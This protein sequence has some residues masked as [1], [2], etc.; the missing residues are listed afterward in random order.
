[1]TRLNQ[2]LAVEK[3]LKATANRAVTDLY[4]SFQK[5]AL[6]TGISR[7]YR[8]AD[9]DSKELL[10]AENQPV[11][12]NAFRALQDATRALT[13]LIDVTAV[14]DYANTEA[15]ADVKI[16]GRV[17]LEAVP[18]SHLLFLEKQLID[19]QTM[20]NKL[21]VL[22]PSVEWTYDDNAESYRSKAVET[23]RSKK[24]PRNHVLAAATDKHPAQVQ[25][26]QEDVL[27]GYWTKTDFS[28]AVPQ[29]FV[30]TL[31]ERIETVAAAIKQARE[32]ANMIEVQDQS[33]GAPI[34]NYVLTGKLP[35]SE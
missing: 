2:I 8:P 9:D 26:Y 19:L 17:L 16:N 1:M 10:P 21:P 33:I 29:A 23:H 22:D 31:I 5:T 28:G 32:Q 4:H 27:V 13:R 3:G 11:R 35:E 6:F 34:M 12:M 24:V 18:V 15:F 20:V 7:V 25:V 30:R 14:K